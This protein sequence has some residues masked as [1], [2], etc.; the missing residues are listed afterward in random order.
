MSTQRILVVE[1]ELVV[2]LDLENRLSDMGFEVVAVVASGSEAI[3]QVRATAVDL[4]LMDIKL[5]GEMDGIEAAGRIREHIDVPIIFV[6]AFADE[7]TTTRVKA[8]APYGYVVKPFQKGAL[9]AVIDGALSRAEMARRLR[10]SERARAEAHAIEK[11]LRIRLEAVDR[12]GMAVGRALAGLDIEE[13][14]QVVVDEARTVADAEY[15][16]L[17]VVGEPGQAFEPWVF[18]GISKEQAAAIG[19][20]PRPF[21]LLGAVVETGKPIRI[22][23]LQQ[24]EAFRGFPAHHPQMK[25]FLGVPIPYRSESRGNLYLANKRGWQEFTDDDQA[26]IEM[27]VERV[28]ITLEIARLRQIEARERTRLEFLAR[29]GAALAESLDYAATLEAIA[30]LIVPSVAEMCTLDLV[31]EEGV[32]GKV[33][34]RHED[35]QRQLLLEQLL[36]SQQPA[37]IAEPRQQGLGSGQPRIL[38]D[39][40]DEVLDRTIFDP[41][42]REIIRQVAPKSAIFVPLPIRGQTI[43]VLQVAVGASRRRLGSEDVPLVAEIG[44]VAALAIENARLYEASR[45]REEEQRF[46]A[47]VGT[48]LASTLDY[49]E[50]LK[51]V[52]RLAVR[53]LADWCVVDLADDS[54]R[55]RRLEVVH[56]NPEKGPLCEVLE[57]VELDPGR[58]RLASAVWETKQSIVVREVEA[59]YVRLI[60]QNDEHLRALIELEPKSVMALPLLARDRLIG[61]IIL[62]SSHPSRRYGAQDLALAQQ[63]ADRAALAV[64]NAQL[65]ELARRAIQAREDMMAIVSHD[66]RGPLSTIRLSVALLSRPVPVVERRKG[67]KHLEL[68]NRSVTFLDQLIEGLR[69]AAMIEAGQFT[70]E[71]EPENVPAILKEAA[72]LLKPQTDALELELTVEIA[73]D[74]PAIRCDRRRILQVLCNLVGNAGKFTRSGGHIRIAARPM[75]DAL[76]VSVSDTGAGIPES[77]IPYIFD[78]YW[79]GK[80]KNKQGTGLGLYISRAIVEAH[81]GTLWVESKIDGGSTFSFRL[82]IAASTG[83]CVASTDGDHSRYPSVTARGPTPV[84]ERRA[85]GTD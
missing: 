58:P 6:T 7:A 31:D 72:S 41:A 48:A 61:V 74:I 56:R 19:G 84:A 37:R 27:L 55:V 29:A 38:Q 39:I 77:Q 50:T 18:S 47:E 24:H 51:T 60:A 2:G 83:E 43:G 1:D 67:Q 70:V 4:V 75:D 5:S 28:A 14:L 54:G 46:L 59:D 66:L 68:I 49:G 81:G 26:S 53:N 30:N 22:A 79:K 64:E 73:E 85:H 3:E 52:A 57:G 32:S 82:P 62:V 65:Y 11:S 10:E 42:H 71:P 12:A 35:P 80:D 17:G 33:M 23:D 63:L 16:A 45:Q 69:D 20:H 15:A 40:T 25:S 34:V 9:R 36:G 78:R 44:N 76:C 13:F 8:I 21:R